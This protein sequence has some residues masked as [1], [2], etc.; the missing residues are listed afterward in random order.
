[1]Q[2]MLPVSDFCDRWAASHSPLHTT[3]SVYHLAIWINVECNIGVVC[4][5]L[6]VMRTLV[7]KIYPVAFL[8]RFSRSRGGYSSQ[9]GSQRLT[10]EENSRISQKKT[11]TST[12][13]GVG[14]SRTSIDRGGSKSKYSAWVSNKKQSKNE[15]DMTGSMEEMVPMG[16][17]TVQHDI[18]WTNVPVDKP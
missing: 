9:K 7:Q 12:V 16:N 3:G 13:E 17:I 2:R 4:T 8:S 10:D 18:E 15:G 14:L 5:C 6:P 11:V 1:M